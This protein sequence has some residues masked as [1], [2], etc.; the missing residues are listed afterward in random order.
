MIYVEHA[1]LNEST[2]NTHT[3]PQQEPATFYHQ[4]HPCCLNNVSFP[5]LVH[6]CSSKN[7]INIFS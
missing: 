5:K 4:N 7:P 6:S 2:Y 3:L 1:A